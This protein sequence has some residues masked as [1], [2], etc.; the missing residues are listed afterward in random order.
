VNVRSRVELPAQVDRNVL[1]IAK[2]APYPTLRATFSPRETRVSVVFLG[3]AEKN[4]AELPPIS[5]RLSFRTASTR[6]GHS[7]DGGER[8]E[9]HPGRS[10]RQSSGGADRRGVR[11]WGSLRSRHRRADIGCCLGAPPA[12]IVRLRPA[13]PSGGSGRLNFLYSASS[14]LRAFDR[15]G[16][17]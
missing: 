16:P 17:C 6:S 1:R 14:Y 7:Q 9:P 8:S 3:C 15:K 10:W 4:H 12:V 11:R 2:S 13:R 5:S